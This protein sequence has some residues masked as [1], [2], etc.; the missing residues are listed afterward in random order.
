MN[1]LRKRILN[2]SYKHDIGHIGSSITAVDIIDEIYEEKT[3]DDIFILSSG[4]AGLAL[5]VVL[6][7][8]YGLDAEH[9]YLKHGLHPRRDCRD[10]IHCS[11]GSLGC[12][13][14][15]GVGMAIANRNRNIYVLCSDGETGEGS[16]WEALNFIGDNELTNIYIYVNAN[17]F[18]A[19]KAVDGDAL[20][21]KI[22]PF[23]PEEQLFFRAT[24]CGG[25]PFL[26]GLSAHYVHMS[27]ANHKAI[28]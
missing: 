9:L 25:I 20:L 22:Q 3:P 13:I 2:L 23:L 1:A 14:C 11:T 7:K 28:Q 27:E 12:G 6:E 17:G 26:N 18:S 8:R 24:D 5:Y 16:F 19:C 21:K 15:V 4:H 10:H